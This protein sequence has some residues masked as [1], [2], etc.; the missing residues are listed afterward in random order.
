LIL[1]R[2]SDAPG[3]AQRI[4]AGQKLTL[5]TTAGQSPRSFFRRIVYLNFG[6]PQPVESN[7][8]DTSSS[9]I[10][11]SFGVLDYNALNPPEGLSKA[12]VSAKDGAAA[13]TLDAPREVRSVGISL[14]SGATSYTVELFRMDGDAISEKPTDSFLVGG[15]RIF[16][17]GTFET[18]SAGLVDSGRIIR[19][20]SPSAAPEFTDARFAI[21]AKTGRQ[22]EAFQP[23]A[24]TNLGLRSYPTTPR[25]GLFVTEPGGSGGPQFQSFWQAAGEIGKGSPAAGGSVNAGPDLAKALS[26]YL[27]RLG[28]PLPANLVVGVA[29]ESDAPCSF[30]FTQF[31]IVW[32]FVTNSFADSPEKRVLRFEGA[33]HKS[34][35]VAIRMSRSSNV[36]Q[37]ELRVQPN[38]GSARDSGIGLGDTADPNPARMQ[39]VALNGGRS[40]AQRIVPDS[41]FSVS[42]VLIAWMSLSE[43]TSITLELREDWQDAPTGALLAS[44]QAASDAAGIPSWMTAAFSK[45]VVLTSSPHWIVVKAAKGSGVWFAEEAQNSVLILEN[46]TSGAAANARSLPHLGLLHQFLSEQQGNGNNTG[47]SLQVNG[48]Q[49]T[50]QRTEGKNLVFEL[51]TVLTQS[52]QDSS[53][54][55]SVDIPLVFASGLSGSVTVYPPA[56]QYDL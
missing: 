37:A 7:E 45:P 39:A 41:A 16:G 53:L 15:S 17:T 8:I 22:Y 24:L 36:T 10:Q 43:R 4:A 14:P 51:A 12:S 30:D 6:N 13:A 44:G 25:I 28:S 34:Q 35:N 50:P 49:V 23:S 42:G 31:S 18:R 21:R 52:L 56:I 54:P 47:F 33:S 1:N 55:E 9:I 27:L 46:E 32:H 48:I 20:T 40:V 5:T 11:G 26:D 19:V 29:V 2:I 3:A 38:F